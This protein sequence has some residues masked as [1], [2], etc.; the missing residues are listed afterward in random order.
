MDFGIIYCIHIHFH[1]IYTNGNNKM[2]KLGYTK[3]PFARMMTYCDMSDDFDLV[4]FKFTN[5]PHLIEGVVFKILS[6]YRYGSGEFFLCDIDLIKKVFD[7]VI[8]MSSDIN[9]LTKMNPR[10]LCRSKKTPNIII[11][12]TKNE[13]P[14]NEIDPVLKNIIDVFKSRNKTSYYTDNNVLIDCNLA[15]FGDSN[16][17]VTNYSA[18]FGT[19]NTIVGS[20]N[21]I[22]SSGNT[23]FGSNN[24]IMN[25]D[26]DI[27]HT[28]LNFYRT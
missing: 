15:I 28:S 25:N 21:I 8:L 17:V 6:Q 24:I 13:V 3:S 22:F 10:K 20:Y 27:V 5:N 26:N 18:I 9:E 2:Y 23:I 12:D 11:D 7:Q 14:S 19:N 16:Y 4:Y 1:D